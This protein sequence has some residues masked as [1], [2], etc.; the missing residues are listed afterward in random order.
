MRFLINL[1]KELEKSFPPH[2]GCHHAFTYAQFG[3]DEAGW[4]DRLLLTMSI[5]KFDGLGAQQSEFQVLFI[6]EG[7]FEKPM[8]DLIRDIRVALTSP[9]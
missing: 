9:A 5:V 6:D 2:A 1:L 3:S 7:D 8:P 4:S